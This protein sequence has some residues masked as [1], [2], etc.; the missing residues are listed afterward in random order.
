MATIRPTP[1]AVFR[2]FIH[3]EF[4]NGA[5]SR[6]RHQNLV[7][8]EACADSRYGVFDLLDIFSKQKQD[9]TAL[10]HLNSTQAI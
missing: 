5:I 2:L 9:V 6:Y 10:D 3:L 8:M 4:L 1:K 7:I